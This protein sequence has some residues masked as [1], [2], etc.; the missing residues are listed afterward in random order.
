MTRCWIIE[1]ILREFEFLETRVWKIQWFL[2]GFSLNVEKLKIHQGEA[3]LK[4][5]L[6]ESY[7]EV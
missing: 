6:Q 2:I 7:E 1:V 3:I 4:L 5:L